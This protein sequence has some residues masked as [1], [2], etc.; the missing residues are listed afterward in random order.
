MGKPKVGILF[1]TS[2]W[3]RQVGLQDGKNDLTSE[4]EVFGRK[5][6]ERLKLFSEPQYTGVIYSSDTAAKASA[7][8]RKSNVSV[9]LVS[10]LIWCEDQV[11]RAALKHLPDL[12]IILLTVY[13][14]PSLSHYLPYQ[15]MLKGSGIV[16]T[17]QFSGMLKREG[18]NYC[19]V[20]G[21]YQDDSLYEDLFHHFTSLN[22][23]EALKSLIVGILP[24][25]C[26]HMSTT[27]V[28][29]FT[30]RR[31]YGIET[32]YLEISRF[33]E[34]AKK[35]SVKEINL[36]KK[37]YCH[38]GWEIKVSDKDLSE[39]IR[40]ALAI[41]K[42]RDEEGLGVLAMND[43]IDE[44]HK[45]FGL[46]PSLDNPELS[47]TEFTVSMEADVAS[48]VGMYILKMLT[49]TPLLYT[50]ILGVD[51]NNNELLLGHAGYHDTSLADPEIPVTVVNDIEY[52]TTDR[53]KGACSCFKTKP[54]KVT[55]I[56]SVFHKERFTWTVVTGESLP[57][58]VKL[59]DTVHMVVAPDLPVTEMI[60]KSIDQ[61][62]SQHWL[63]VSGDQTK[64]INVLARW[65][66]IELIYLESE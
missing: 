7:Q 25:H 57:G 6:V 10:P 66:D 34:E 44:M 2:N 61:G 1:V 4:V 19:S 51:I 49:G 43:V 32:R 24:F 28:D 5:I 13:P 8:I 52:K 36:F 9:L 48:G 56:N 62:V 53:L 46:R 26:D 12:P 39:G 50:E 22:I 15:E 60:N 64:K 21:Y 16:G 23:K 29:D 33:K 42:I 59:E 18:R 20:S 3:F 38:Q 55:L 14:D 30:L 40:Y 11:I 37:K 58:P 41:K 17:M 63:A 54:G 45:A 31:T 47:A 35:C 65:L 27:F